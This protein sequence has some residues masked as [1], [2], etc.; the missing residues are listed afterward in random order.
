MY[1]PPHFREDRPEVQLGLIAAHPLGLLISHGDDG[2]LADPLPFMHVAGPEPAGLLRAHMARANPHWRRL[3]DGGDV[4]VVFQGAQAYVTPAWYAAKREHGKVVPTWN[5]LTVQV[6]GRATVT[7]AVDWL[8]GQTAALTDRMEAGRDEPWAVK[9]APEPF[10]ASQLKAIVGLEVRIER[11][12]G[13]WKASQNRSP[14]DR[15]G[16]REG[17]ALAGDDGAAL[18][19]AMRE[20]D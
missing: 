3:A 7:D 12:V 19:A 13:K 9:D 16:V 15:A 14:A 1:L 17:L 18:A 6:R 20:A 4:L 11:I 10:V 5:Y 2:L 8:G